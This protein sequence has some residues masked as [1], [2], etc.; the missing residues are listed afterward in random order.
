MGRIRTVKPEFFKHD[1]LFDA[2]VEFGLP[3]R[4]AFIGLWTQ[5]D[6]EGRFAWRERRLKAEV[7]PYDDIDMARVLD[8][9]ATRGFVVRYVCKG[10]VYGFIPGFLRHQVINNRE[11][12]SELPSPPKNV[13][14]TNDCTGDAREVDASPTREVRALGE[15]KGREGKGKEGE[16]RAP[17]YAFEGKVIRLTKPDFETWRRAFHKLDLRAELTRLDAYYTDKPPTDGKWFNRVSRI[18]ADEHSKKP[19]GPYSGPARN[20]IDEVLG[21][22]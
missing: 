12:K 22:G 19:D 21:N 8:A 1:E 11:A 20:G 13:E 17:S 2:E 18:L 10:R 7:F 5:C 6:R 3:L 14:E 9:L 15:R 4:L 16:A